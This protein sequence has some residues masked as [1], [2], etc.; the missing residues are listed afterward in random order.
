MSEWNNEYILKITKQKL[1]P[2]YWHKNNINVNYYGIN[3]R[4]GFDK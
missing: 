2:S 3:H 1:L 4:C